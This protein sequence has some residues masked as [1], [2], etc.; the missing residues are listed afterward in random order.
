M[1]YAWAKQ[2][3]RKQLCEVEQ[4]IS[5]CR[6]EENIKGCMFYEPE[7]NMDKDIPCYLLL[8]D[9]PHRLCGVMSSF[10]PT[11]DDCELYA[12]VHPVYRRLG[13]FKSMFALMGASLKKYSVL[14]GA[15]V[16][17]GNPS[18]RAVLSHMGFSSCTSD[19]LLCHHGGKSHVCGDCQ[20]FR[21]ETS[22]DGSDEKSGECFTLYRK[23]TPVGRCF[24]DY[25]EGSTTLYGVEIFPEYRKKG[26]SSILMNLCLSYLHSPEKKKQNAILLHVEGNNLPALKTYQ[27]CGFETVQ[28]L[29]YYR[30]S[31]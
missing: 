29:F 6:R 25:T 9:Q 21:L 8:Y 26:Y 4:L 1:E 11:P 24:A 3:N 12:Y 7:W 17:E 30:F 19:L 15:F 2:L 20:D 23:H 10:V 18:S 31:L 5:E 28:T 27:K 14:G 13:Y 22:P 16:C